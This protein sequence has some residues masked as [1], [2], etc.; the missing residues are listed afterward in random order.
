MKRT[1]L[2]CLA[3]TGLFAD[4]TGI[5]PRKTPDSYP[6]HETAGGV[7]LA[8]ALLTPAEGRTV[9]IADLD[10]AGY[11]IFEV[12]LYPASGQQIGL[13]PDQFTLRA[14]PTGSILATL[15]PGTI[16]DRMMPP[17]KTAP[18]VPSPVNVSSTTV[19]GYDSGG[20]GRRGGVYAGESTNVGIGNPPPQPP[21]PAAGS[22]PTIDRDQLVA[23][24][25]AREFPET[26]ATAPVAGYLYFPKSDAKPKNGF[27]ELTY[28]P[29]DRSGER[30]ILQVPA[31]AK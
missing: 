9:F 5:P 14:N 4:V 10:R 22:K 28:T 30:I 2:V 27:Y 1:L 6:T 13:G 23:E 24:L 29:L 15:A 21:P 17:K 7:T 16:V 25:T 19:I 26:K 20:A 18:Q 31:K 3:A 8:A 12:A 11:L